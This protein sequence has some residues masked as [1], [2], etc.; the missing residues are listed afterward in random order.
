[1][2]RCRAR[3]ETV[4]FPAGLG[5]DARRIFDE[6]RAGLAA[7]AA[8]A[9]DVGRP[10]ESVG[11]DSW[12]VDYGL[13][14]GDG[15]LI[16]DPIC[17][18]DARTDGV[19]ADAFARISREELVART[20]IQVLPFNTVFQLFAHVRAGIPGAARRILLM[21]DL[22]HGFLSGVEL[23]EFTNA[24][25]T[26]LINATSGTWDD[27]VI[28]RLGLPRDLLAPI[29]P[30]GRVLGPLRDELRSDTGLHCRQVVAPATH[31]T[32]SAV[33]GTPLRPG[34]AF[35]SSGTWS[36]V[37]IE[38]SQPLI[39]VDLARHNFTTE[40][41]VATTTRFLK[42]VAGMWLLECCRRSR[43]C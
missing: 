8:R 13:V 24:T 18:R 10:V 22:V 1:M 32:G 33:A 25:T 29:V 31:D 5:W 14:D 11:V 27:E 35:I 34:W 17:Y 21:P 4:P 41:G 42:N 23:T 12:G 15:R 43:R 3:C 9:R 2:P 6:V 7:A 16:D 28:D 19:L 26:Q 20:G 40:G 38:R 30:A 39:D 37:G 36:L